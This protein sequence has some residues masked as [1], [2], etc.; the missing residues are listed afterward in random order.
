[1]TG[2]SQS[3]ASGVS[4]E[5]RRRIAVGLYESGLF[6]TWY[7]DQSAGWTLVSGLWSPIYLQLRELGSHPA[8]LRDVG[9]ALAQLLREDVP[10]AD[11]LVGI[12]YAGI[13]IAIA[14]SL[15]SGVPAAM[16]RKLEARSESEINDALRSYGQ[17]ASVE[18]LLVR[19]GARL[20]LVDDLVTGFDSKLVAARQVKHE[21]ERRGFRGTLCK[22]VLVVVD[23][24]QGG[25]EAAASHGFALHALLR[26]RT[27]CL[28]LLR[29]QLAPVEHEIVS[30]YLDDPTPFQDPVEQKR[31]AAIAAERSE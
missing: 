16:T 14:A 17:H 26:L 24:E 13:P 5:L 23:R 30:S 12:A 27:E 10:D 25:S 3:G 7:R 29:D 11:A 31:L 2:K 8:L 15:A 19:D 20:V 22:D 9:E 4:L 6:R 28:P 1:M 18:G 21:A